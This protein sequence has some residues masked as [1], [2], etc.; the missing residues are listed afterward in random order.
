MT[1]VLEINS[2]IMTQTK[3]TAFLGRMKATILETIG[4]QDAN[5]TITM[6]DNFR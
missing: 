1:L 6:T 2:N 3:I 5:P 4:L